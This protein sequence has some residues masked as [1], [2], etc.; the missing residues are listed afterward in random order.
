M[1]GR[2]Y[3]VPQNKNIHLG[4]WWTWTCAK[5]YV[6]RAIDSLSSTMPD[7]KRSLYT[8][9]KRPKG[10]IR[11]DSHTYVICIWYIPVIA[12]LGI[13]N[14]NTQLIH[15]CICK[16]IYNLPRYFKVCICIIFIHNTT[17]HQV[18]SK[19]V[20]VNMHI[21]Y[22]YIIYNNKIEKKKVD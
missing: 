1:H 3:H 6:T 18:P 5:F 8:T 7:L 4:R 2:V 19:N 12:Y 17:Y 22:K 9:H 14:D 10:I 15:F 13:D 11:R 16:M 20:N 21:S